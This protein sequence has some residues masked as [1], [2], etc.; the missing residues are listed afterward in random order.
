MSNLTKLIEGLQII[1]AKESGSKDYDFQHDIMH[2][3]NI[4]EYT[5]KEITKLD[6]L[7]FHVSDDDESFYT[8]S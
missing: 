6:E 3:G 4:C 5:E 1:D 7:G 8:F 2:V